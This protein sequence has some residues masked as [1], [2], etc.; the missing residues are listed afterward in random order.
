MELAE[1]TPNQS[2][3]VTVGGASSPDMPYDTP[4]YGTAKAEVLSP[5]QPSL[6]GLLGEA[7]IRASG[8][9]DPRSFR[10]TTLP[11]EARA[12]LGEAGEMIET[13]QSD[14]ALIEETS[15]AW[16]VKVLAIGV[17]HLLTEAAGRFSDACTAAGITLPRD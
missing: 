5:E 9:S 12:A 13:I 2:T 16:R 8:L 17:D 10:N 11:P 3:L 4:E 14:L 7:M 6:G 1:Y 15:A